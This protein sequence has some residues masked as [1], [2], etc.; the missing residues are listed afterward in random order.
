MT[1]KQEIA[2]KFAQ[3]NGF[4]TAVLVATKN[5]W[6]YFQMKWE[7]QPRYTGHPNVIKISRAGKVLVVTDVEEIYWAVGEAKASEQST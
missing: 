7:P 1:S 2:D 4:Q 5:G 3:K 6:A